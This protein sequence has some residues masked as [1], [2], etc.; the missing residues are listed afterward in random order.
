[1][2][3][4]IIGD[5]KAS[6]GGMYLGFKL[7]DDILHDEKVW[8]RLCAALRRELIREVDGDER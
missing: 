4:T 8:L 7:T 2:D 6:A 5:V 1:M 3:D